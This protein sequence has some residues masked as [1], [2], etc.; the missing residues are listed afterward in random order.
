MRIAITARHV[1][2]DD[3]LRAHTRELIEKI[4]KLVRRPGGA[5]VIFSEDHGEAAVEIEL[6]A[7]RARVY[8]AKAVAADHRSALDEAIGRLK[9]QLSDEKEPPR[10]RAR[11][12]RASTSR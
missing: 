3:T 8:I 5:Q 6:S 1:E 11:G 2:I 7:P 12:A 9:R 10:R 4:A